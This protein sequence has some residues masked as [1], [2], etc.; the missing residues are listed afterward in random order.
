M[1][2]QPSIRLLFKQTLLK[3]SNTESFVHNSLKYGWMVLNLIVKDIE[4]FVDDGLD[5]N[6]YN[7]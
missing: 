7:I 3:F 4:V 2:K 1:V 6:I 5:Y